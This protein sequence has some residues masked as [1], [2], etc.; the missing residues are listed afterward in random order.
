MQ[1]REER[2]RQRTAVQQ[3]NSRHAELDE[4]QVSR[5]FFSS[6]SLQQANSRHAELDELQ[7]SDFTCFTS[8]EVQI[9]GGAA[10]L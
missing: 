2:D 7:A 10:C 6:F 9:A 8:T 5:M 4:L 1:V 3:A